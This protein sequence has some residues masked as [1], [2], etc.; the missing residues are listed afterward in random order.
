[1]RVEWK[2]SPST[3]GKPDGRLERL[4]LVD[5]ASA[6]GDSRFEFLA[7]DVEAV[8]KLGEARNR[9]QAE[10]RKVIVGMDQVTDEVMIAIFSAGHGLLEGVPGLA[11]TQLI[12]SIAKTLSL[13]FRRIQCT[14]DLMPSDITGTEIQQD[15]PQ[16]GHRRFVFSK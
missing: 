10:L 1:M 6:S 13:S 12:S 2:P 7:D 16:T 4:D 11:K 15:D 3:S 5:P 8:K 9:V 14:P